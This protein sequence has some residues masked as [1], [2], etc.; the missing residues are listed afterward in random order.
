MSSGA[1]PELEGRPGALSELERAERLLSSTPGRWRVLYHND[2]DGIASASVAARAL[3]RWGRRWQLTALFSLEEGRIRALLARTAGPV[4]VVDTGESYLELLSLHPQPVIVLDHH[5]PLGPPPPREGLV[6]V[7]PHHWGVDGMSE[8]SAS[9]LTYLFARRLSEENTDLVAWAFAG[10]VADRMHVGGFRGLNQSVLA[11]AE[12]H[13]LLQ[14]RPTLS[15]AEGELARSIAGSV[16]PYYRG[17]SGNPGAARNF[18]EG[19]GEDPRG[20]LS[21]LRPEA[22]RRLTSALLLQLIAQGTRPEFCERVREERL[23][24]QPEEEDVGWLSTLQNA[25]GREGRPSLGIALALG[26][27]S[28][29]ERAK[30][31]EQ[32]WRSRVLAELA[33]LE[34]GEGLEAREHLQAFSLDE[35]ALAGPVAGLALAYL[36]DPDRPVFALAR[37]GD[38]VK[39]SARGTPRLTD[40]GLDLAETCRRA[41]QAVGG[42]GGGH[43]VA[44]GASIPKGEEAAFLR[45]ADRLLAG[46]P[47][48]AGGVAGAGGRSDSP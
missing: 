42:E 48:H 29:R 43:R 41:A 6:V 26:D 23:L 28:A 15:L 45:E 9:V 34:R 1:L 25:C 4:L 3:S 40:R 32:H 47:F 21:S 10:A 33:R 22:L 38:V 24:L 2:G 46:Q 36:L 7:N 16:D 39:V 12:A 11:R 18:L 44:S 13:G 31:L 8:C 20:L 14:R 19:L 30:E 37:Q 17:L 27:R 35:P 5:R